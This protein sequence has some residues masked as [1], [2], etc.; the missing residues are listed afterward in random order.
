M[1]NA[2]PRRY[3][4]SDAA[5]AS[6]F[7]EEIVPAELSA[8]VGVDRPVVVF[9]AG[10]PGAGKTRT[11]ET[12]V[13]G[14]AVRGSAIV[15][16]SDFY[17]PYHPRYQELLETDD[18]TAAAYTSLDGRRWMAQAEAYLLRRRVNTVI[19][20]TMRDP[21]DFVE[22][23]DLF[24][25]AG[26]RVEVAIL[27]VPAALSRLGIVARYHQQ[28]QAAGHGRLTERT[29][30]DACYAGVVRTAEHL[31]A[32]ALAHSVAVYR[33]G[34]HLLYSNT[35]TPTGTW[36]RPP[37][38]VAAVTAERTR[39]W[40]TAEANDFLIHLY[41]LERELGPDWH[42]ELD[43]IIH[44]ARPHLPRETAIT[45]DL[46][47]E[48][49]LPRRDA[50]APHPD[51]TSAPRREPPTGRS[52]TAPPGTATPV[53]AETA[54]TGRWSDLART[55]HPGLPDTPGWSVLAAALDRAHAA[56][57]DVPA[58]LPRLVDQGPLDD[59]QPARDLHYRL[60]ADCD[61]AR[62]PTPAGVPVDSTTPTA[63]PPATADGPAPHR[64]T[65]RR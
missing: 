44:L 58:N 6:I 8:G 57:Y 59:R 17:K 43:E 12:V 48:S 3:L 47:A 61:A 27:A 45:G 52:P 60:A 26:Y 54:Y 23:A 19:E 36:Q 5:S 62:T 46:E 18:R 49:V 22:P 31:D 20:T 42:P 13:A 53:Q 65:P 29:N 9:V 28:V 2:D 32:R 24:R 50:A 15:V 41:R 21:G 35:L 10:Q 56:G 25:G 4:L 63:P 7:D 37:V 16:N 34:N 55:V 1:S 39:L 51:P 30:H 33:R 14:F 38:T 40:S 11:T 64:D